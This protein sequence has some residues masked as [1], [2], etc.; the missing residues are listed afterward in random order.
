MKIRVDYSK[1][2]IKDL[3]KAPKKVKIAFRNRLEL[4]LADKYHPLLNNHSLR[5]GYGQY[6]SI[7]I[8]GDWRVIFRELENGERIYFDRLGTHSQLYK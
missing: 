3:R 8:S 4:L 7:N 5:G 2:F 6:R 1:R